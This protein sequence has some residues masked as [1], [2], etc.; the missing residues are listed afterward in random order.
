MVLQELQSTGVH[1]PR[2]GL[3]LLG[4][5]GTDGRS[6]DRRH[7]FVGQGTFVA[8][9]PQRLDDERPVQA[10]VARGEPVV[11]AE[12]DVEDLSLAPAQR[13]DQVGFFD[14]EVERVE[15]DAD[16]GQADLLDE[17]QRLGHV[18]DQ[19]GLEPVERLQ[20]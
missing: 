3:H 10:P 12:V 1:V 11:V 16:V 8:D 15:R 19:V 6:I 7:G 20:R 17:L 9:L 14:V 18:G 5:K 2:L 4:A 13:G